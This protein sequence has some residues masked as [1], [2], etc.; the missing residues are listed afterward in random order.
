MNIR[1]TAGALVLSGILSAVS[2]AQQ[3]GTP[4]PAEVVLEDL[5]GT[6]A[7]SFDDFQGRAVLIEFFAYW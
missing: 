4:L 1:T 5:S 3:V 6:R 2:A 7:T